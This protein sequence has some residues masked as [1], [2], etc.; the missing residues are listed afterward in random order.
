LLYYGLGMGNGTARKAWFYPYF[1]P[2]HTKFAPDLLFSK[3]AKTYNQSVV[4]TT[5]ELQ[6]F[7][8]QYVDVVADDGSI[9]SDWRNRLSKYSKCPGIWSLYDFLFL[10]NSVTGK[11]V[12]KVHKHC[13]SG[14]YT[15]STTH[16]LD[17]RVFEENVLCN[18]GDT[19]QNKQKIKEISGTKLV[20]LRH[21][22]TAHDRWLT[23]L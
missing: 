18:E 4:F 15:N 16:L 7:V 11:V 20:N 23:F 8:L 6:N 9:V 5:V 1:I 3:T 13:Y 10:K 14:N 19:Y 2:G 22:Y 12:S 17:G 21:M